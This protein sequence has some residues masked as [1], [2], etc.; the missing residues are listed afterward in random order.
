M[1]LHSLLASWKAGLSR[2]R[3]PQPRP[4]RPH[5]FRPRLEALE[6]RCVPSTLN[7]TSNA[8][9]GAA[10][11]LRW[12]VGVANAN[13]AGLDTIDIL[14]TQ[15]IVLT[16]G[17][18]LLGGMRTIEATA[19]RA[20]IS[21]NGLSRVFQM[22]SV[23]I[24]LEDL[25]I[26]GGNAGAGNGGAILMNFGILT[27]T[28]CTLSGNSA[29]SGGAIA[30]D[31]GFLTVTNC[32][33]SGNS[34]AGDGGAIYSVFKTGGSPYDKDGLLRITSCTLS[35][36]SA[37]YG[38]AIAVSAANTLV[39]G[40][41]FSNNSAS[42]Q[43]GAI[44]GLTDGPYYSYTSSWGTIHI[45]GSTFAGNTPDSVYAGQGESVIY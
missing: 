18:L 13:P 8:D 38:G 28:N 37:E 3:R 19:G 23:N 15:P 35:S 11:T 45:S 29:S 27:V 7:V 17:Q 1:W 12:A 44:D 22:G 42:V 20:T 25:N 31:G 6:D 39:T 9:T 21:G 4:A 36:N 16:Q 34:A 26:T 40:C 10:G 41:A 24:T 43:G 5:S 2:R 33:L 32:T 14:T 30:N